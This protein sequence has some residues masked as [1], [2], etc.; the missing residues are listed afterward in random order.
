MRRQLFILPP[1]IEEAQYSEMRAAVPIKIVHVEG[2]W[3]AQRNI[4]GLDTPG[5]RPL[6]MVIDRERLVVG[7]TRR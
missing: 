4:S 5:K 7:G 3:A 6:S 1:Q 2:V